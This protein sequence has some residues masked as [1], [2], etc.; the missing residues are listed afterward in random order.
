LL[1]Q[2]QQD[3]RTILIDHLLR[4]QPVESKN[5]AKNPKEIE[6]NVKLVDV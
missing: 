6:N 1:L 5:E 3:I 4:D 2:S